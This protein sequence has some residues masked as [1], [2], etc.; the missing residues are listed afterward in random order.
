[1][2]WDNRWLDMATLVASWSKDHSRKTACVIVD[3]RN[4][5][6]AIGW[7]GFPRGVNDG[8]EYRHQRPAKYQWTEHAERNA[9]YNAA[10][11]GFS[12]RGCTMFSLWYLCSD[13]TRAVIQSG[14]SEYVCPEPDWTDDRWA[15]EFD[16]SKGMMAEAGIVSR[17]V[18]G[19]APL[20]AS[21]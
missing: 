15:G 20:A 4:V 5:L 21:Q 12:V 11:N 18:E 1:M 13:C 9:I 3:D 17:F 2:S 10:A 6:V 16:I 14:I 19:Y 7:N 8:P